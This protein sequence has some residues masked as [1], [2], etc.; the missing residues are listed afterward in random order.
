MLGF[1]FLPEVMK[2]LWHEFVISVLYVHGLS[3][4]IENSIFSCFLFFSKKYRILTDKPDCFTQKH[5]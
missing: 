5:Q 3:S 2:I 4:E 1:S